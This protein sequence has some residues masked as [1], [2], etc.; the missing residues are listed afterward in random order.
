MART[1][2][3]LQIMTRVRELVDAVG[4]TTWLTDAEL[5]K[6]VDAAYTDLVDLLIR[7]EQHQFETTANLTITAGVA[8]VPAD[9][10]KALAVDYLYATGQYVEVPQSTFAE[11]NN[12]HGIYDFGTASSASPWRLV[13]GNIVFNPAPPA[14][15]TYRLT[16]IPAP[17]NIS[18]VATSTAVD[19]VAGWDEWIVYQAAMACGEKEGAPE[20]ADWEKRRDLL[21]ARIMQMGVDRSPTMAIVDTRDDYDGASWMPWR[22]S[23]W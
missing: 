5:Q 8:P 6:K 2:T 10:Y 7:A 18:Q 20:L 3:V 19:G 1:Q 12:R 4:D 13:G 14:G 9:F 17:A 23:R 21:T 16:Y 11:R 15:A 22:R